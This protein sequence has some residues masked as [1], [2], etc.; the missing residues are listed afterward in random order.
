MNQDLPHIPERTLKPYFGGTLFELF[1]VRNRFDDFR[2]MLDRYQ[3][4]FAEVSDGS[5]AIPHGE[6]LEYIRKL[7][8]QVTV[9]SEVG[10]KVAGVEIP[11]LVSCP[12]L[13]TIKN[14]DYTSIK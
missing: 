3:V 12:N 9:I 10:S 11:F 14:Y 1:V 13:F 6:K 7:A 4:E 5:M 2:K 8:E